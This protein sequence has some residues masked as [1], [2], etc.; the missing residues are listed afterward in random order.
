MGMSVSSG[1][2]FFLLVAV[3]YL[4]WHGFGKFSE[5]IWIA[6]RLGVDTLDLRLLRKL[7]GDGRRRKERAAEK[8]G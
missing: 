5:P 3:I 7:F 2:A 6:Y 1:L 4:L 8:Q